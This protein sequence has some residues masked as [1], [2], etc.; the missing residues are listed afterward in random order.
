[1]P[2]LPSQLEGLG[3]IVFIRSSTDTTL[4]TYLTL[5]SC[6]THTQIEDLSTKKD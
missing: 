1:M 6:M 5:A 3:S 4:A 2:V